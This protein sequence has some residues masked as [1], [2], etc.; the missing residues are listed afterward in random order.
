MKFN[1]VSF[2][3]W[4][5]HLID[6]TQRWHIPQDLLNLNTHNIAFGLNRHNTL[7][8]LR[9]VRPEDFHSRLLPFYLDEESFDKDF[10]LWIGVKRH[11]CKSG[12]N[13]LLPP[14]ILKKKGLEG[15]GPSFSLAMKKP[16][17]Q[18]STDSKEEEDDEPLESA[19]RIFS[20]L[21]PKNTNWSFYFPIGKFAP[22]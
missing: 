5:T 11:P 16:K 8:W 1:N 3:K 15:V 17:V 7:V 9:H 14:E 10:M 13:Y 21:G 22:T 19:H 18:I 20:F 6:A 12:M 2:A 4:Y